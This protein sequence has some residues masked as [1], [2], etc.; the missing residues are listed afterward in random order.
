MRHIRKIT[1]KKAVEDANDNGCLSCQVST[2]L[3]SLLNKPKD[4]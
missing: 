3:M 4:T 2:L 1:V